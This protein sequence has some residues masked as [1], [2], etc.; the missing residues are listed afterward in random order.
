VARSI[1][2]SPQVLKE[3]QPTNSVA[4]SNRPAYGTIEEVAKQIARRSHSIT[5]DSST[6]SVDDLLDPLSLAAKLRNP[7]DAVSTYLSGR[8]AE[9]TRRAIEAWSGVGEVPQ[10]LQT[11]LIEELNKI[12]TGQGQ[13]VARLNRLLLEDAYPLELSSL[14]SHIAIFLKLVPGG[15]YAE[16]RGAVESA[17]PAVLSAL[18]VSGCAAGRGAFRLFPSVAAR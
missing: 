11:N 15:P 8:F 2:S 3:H 13:E 14:T 16:D 12:V 17:L 18:G 5:S 6:F 9:S 10:S 7:V 1:R 4:G